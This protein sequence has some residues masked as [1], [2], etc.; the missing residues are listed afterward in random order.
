MSDTLINASWLDYLMVAIYFGFVLG[1]GVMARRQVSDSIDFFLSGSLAPGLGHRPGVHLGQPRCGRDHGHVGQRCR[2]RP[3]DGP[4]LLGRCGAGDAVPRRRD[5]AVLLR[6]QGP[7]GPGVHVPSVRHRRPPG[8]RDQLRRRAA[9]HRGRQPR[10]ARRHRARAAGLA[11]LD[12]PH[13]RRRHRAVLHHPRRPER[14]DLQRGAP[15]L[16]HRGLAAAAD[17]HRP[18]PRRRLGRPH[19]QDHRGRRQRACE[20]RRGT[21]RASSSSR[22][23]GRRSRASTRRCSR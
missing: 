6:L 15:V 13:R 22:G 1:I 21:R 10:A 17:P 19:R 2:D 11:D 12:R 4:L 8:Q 23:P 18:P 7:L 9:A 14:G 16:R 5:D 3:A 20:R